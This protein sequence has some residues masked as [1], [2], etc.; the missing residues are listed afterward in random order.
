[1][2]CNSHP[3]VRATAERGAWEL[4]ILFRTRLITLFFFEFCPLASFCKIGRY[5][6]AAHPIL[7]PAAGLN[8]RRRALSARVHA[9][10][11]CDT[12]EFFK[13]KPTGEKQII[14]RGEQLEMSPGMSTAGPG[15]SAPA[16]RPLT[17]RCPRVAWRCPRRRRGRGVPQRTLG[18][19]PR[20]LRPGAGGGCAWRLASAQSPRS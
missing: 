12:S 10:R 1:V 7:R 15:L 13:T 5:L 17:W 9:P 14:T 6:R 16:H 18:V 3:H 19:Q 8:S 20:Q 2:T 4:R 11:E